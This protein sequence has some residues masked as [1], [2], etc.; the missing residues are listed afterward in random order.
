MSG[1]VR[2]ESPPVCRL[3]GAGPASQS[4]RAG[5]VYGGGPEHG[6]WHC[7]ECD[8]V[9]LYP[10]TTEEEEQ[11]FYAREFEGFM[12]ARSGKKADWASAE[13]HKASGRGHLARRWPFLEPYLA[14][15]RDI[16][17]IGCSSGFMLDAFRDAGLNCVGVEPSGVFYEHLAH[18]GYQAYRNLDELERGPDRKFDL[19]VHFFVLEHIRDP[20]DFFRRTLDLLKPGGRIIAEVPCVNDPLTSLY[21]IPA[22]EQFYW[23]IAHHFYYSPKSLGFVLDRL[24]A[25]REILPEQ[26]Y[27]L[28]N[29]MTWMMDGRP[30]GQGRFDHVFSPELLDSYRQDLKRR[31]LCDTM[32]VHVYR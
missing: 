14:P 13:A 10:P 2:V 31:W 21:R 12:A 24:G 9:Y 23:S 6:F 1:P 5:T 26:R 28:S 20:Y 30:G 15:G 7:A 25:G 8:A 29:H 32:F 4:L 22:F 18:S 3:C 19:V 17:E 16:L 27:D 11:R